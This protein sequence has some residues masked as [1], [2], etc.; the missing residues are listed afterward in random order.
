M[1][2]QTHNASA[3]HAIALRRQPTDA[4][5]VLWRRLRSERLGVKFRRQHP[6]ERYVLD[7]V[8]L[9][10]MLVIEVDGGQHLESERDQRRDSF[11]KVAGFQVL[12]FWNHDVIQRT[13]D[14]VQAI[15]W[16]LNPSPQTHPHP[17]PPLEG[18]GERQ[19]P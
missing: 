18:E 6:Y 4:E 9:E 1:H 13:E 2:G 8:C 16:A 19:E 3:S 10:R 5:R 15:H 11:L 14:V 17:S 12:R 7:F